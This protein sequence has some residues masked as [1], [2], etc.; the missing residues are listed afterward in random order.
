M[1]YSKWKIISNVCGALGALSLIAAIITYIQPESSLID[2][3]SYIYR[4]YSIP[5]G[6]IGVVLLVISHYATQ[7]H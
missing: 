7:Q 3:S 4:V 5:L 1:K 2:V 6:I